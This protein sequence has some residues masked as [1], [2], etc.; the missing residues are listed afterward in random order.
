M[1]GWRNTQTSSTRSASPRTTSSLRRVKGLKDLALATHGVNNGQAVK[2]GPVWSLVSGSPDD[3]SAVLT[4]ISELNKYHGLP[5]G[6]FSCDEHLAGLDPYAGLGV[7][8]GSR[9]H[10]FA[11][12][13]ARHRGRPALGDRLE[14][15]AFN[16]L[17]GTF[18]DDMWAHQYNQEPNQVE[19]SLHQKPWTT[20]GPESNL[21]GLEPN[22]GCCTA[23]FHQG[24]PKFT[25]SLFMRSGATGE[26]RGPSRSRVCSLRSAHHFARERRFTWS[27]RRTIPSA[28]QFGCHQS[29]T[30]GEFPAAAPHTG[31]GRGRLDPSQ[32]PRSIAALAGIICPCGAHCGRRAT[33]WRS[34]FR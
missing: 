2:T 31:M 22:F 10:V 30:A 29:R 7:V 3:R 19:C 28:A 11:G 16:A 17:P 26:R 4:M 13:L 5:N 1:T 20:D 25:N 14:K 15:L 33:A 12:A 24:W 18:T 8:H 21:Y 32:R 9:I 23:N 27:K 34:R 6:M